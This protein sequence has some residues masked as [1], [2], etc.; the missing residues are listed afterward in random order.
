MRSGPN[1]TV[2]FPGAI[3]G[4]H[5]SIQCP[6]NTGSAFFNYKG[7]FS[8]VLLA[9]ADADYKFTYVSVGAYGR[10][11]DATIFTKSAFGQRLAERS[12]DIPVAGPGE[13][14]YAFVA[15]EAFPLREQIMRPYPGRRM[16]TDPEKKRIFNYRLSRARRVVENTFGIL[17]SKFRVFRQPINAKLETVD[18]MVKGACVLHNFLRRRDGTSNDRRYI[19]AG[20]VDT[21]D[22][23]TGRLHRGAWRQ[24][25]LGS[26]LRDGGQMGSNSHTVRAGDTRDRLADYFKSPGG[27][28]PWQEA[29]VRR[30]TQ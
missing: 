22:T 4:K 1:Q 28:V 26:G 18:S 20:D 30:G 11:H 25:G 13:L 19:C 16:S 15:D 5:V 7:A 23:T 10:E 29:V 3:D 2:I 17:V 9:V 21:E 24:Q 12:L 8:T 6:A 27:R 14:P